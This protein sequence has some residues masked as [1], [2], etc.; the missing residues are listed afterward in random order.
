MQPYREPVR[1]ITLESQL[2][3]FL[4]SRLSAPTGGLGALP[5]SFSAF[6]SCALAGHWLGLSSLEVVVVGRAAVPR[7][8]LRCG[9]LGRSSGEVSHGTPGKLQHPCPLEGQVAPW[10]SLSLQPKGAGIEIFMVL[11]CVLLLVRAPCFRARLIQYISSF[12]LQ[13]HPH[14]FWHG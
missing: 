4:L 7:G 5:A 12:G 8:L 11:A 1:N 13:W 6:S 2:A 3:H 14:I 9:R 10:R